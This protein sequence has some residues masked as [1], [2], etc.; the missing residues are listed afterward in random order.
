MV[1][2]FFVGGLG[3]NY[4]HDIQIILCG[5]H[6]ISEL[7]CSV[8]QNGLVL[9]SFLFNAIVKLSVFLHVLLSEQFFLWFSLSIV[10]V[11]RT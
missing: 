6:K 7:W 8:E 11:I 5:K 3:S 2:G 9:Y 10:Q 4:F 1:F